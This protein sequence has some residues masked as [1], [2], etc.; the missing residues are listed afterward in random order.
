MTTTFL[1]TSYLLA[2]VLADDEH[3]LRAL[4]WQR[5][6]VGRLLTTEYV[7]VQYVDALAAGPMR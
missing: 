6:L 7:L 5:K 4:A 2:L 3:H 1:N